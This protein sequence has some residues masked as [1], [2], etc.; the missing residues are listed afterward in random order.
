MPP[1]SARL[2]T[3][4]ILRHVGSTTATVWVQTDGP[5][6]VEVLGCRASTF[7]VY[8]HHYALVEVSGLE[9]TSVTDYQVRVDGELSWPLPGSTWPAS[10]IRTRGGGG[11][12]R[13]V[14]GS[15]RNAR[16]ADPKAAAKLG[17]DSLELYAIRMA[18]IPPEDW[19]A[20]LLLLGDQVYADDPPPQTRRWLSLRRHRAATSEREGASDQ[21]ASPDQEANDFAAYAHLYQQTWSEPEVR[22]LLSAVPTAMIFDDHDVRDDWNT[23]AAW[24]RWITAQPWWSARIRGALA[25]YWVY[26][27]IGNLS[28]QERHADPIWCAVQAVQGAG[29]DS[30]PVLREMADTADADP[31]TV[32]WSFRWDID[33]VRLVMVDTR[34]GRMLAEGHRAMLDEPQFRWVEDAIGTDAAATSHVLVGSSLPW[35]LAPAIHDAESANEVACARGSAGA[36]R[37]RQAVDL[38]HWAAFRSSFDRLAALLHRVAAEPQ[39]PATISVLSGDVHHSYVAQVDFDEP[40]LH[41]A[42]YQLVCSPMH[43]RVPWPLRVLLRAAWSGPLT[44]LVRR[45]VCRR[46]LPAPPLSWHR[47]TGPFFGNALATLVFADRGAELVIESALRSG[48]LTPVSRLELGRSGA[49]AARRSPFT[50]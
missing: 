3:G 30:W 11:P 43:H 7:S 40:D 9:P 27:H 24:R 32:R 2:L 20:A 48:Q 10:R 50:R 23:S 38:E 8:G 15:C 26:Q 29:Q 31:A 28:P 16:P 25:S 36:E 39:A 17:A 14:F 37:L 34:C 4:P 12:T 5:A 47:V 46:G 33:G 41:S 35:L 22:W 18:A 42:V 44:R 1:R 19:P 13:V 45:V 21:D 6:E 49:S